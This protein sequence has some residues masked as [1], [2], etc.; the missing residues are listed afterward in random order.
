MFA[1][2]FAAYDALS[3]RMRRY[4]DG[5]TALHSF[6]HGFRHSLAEPGGW[7]RLGEA[8]RAN[9]P[10]RHPVVRTHPRSGRRALFVNR[11]FTTHIEGLREAESDAVLALPVR[12]P[13]DARA[14]LPLSLAARTRS[15]SGTTAPRCIGRSTTTSRRI[16]AWSASPSA[17]TDRDEPAPAGARRLRRRRARQALQGAGATLAGELYR[18]LLQQLEPDAHDRRRRARRARFR[19]ARASSTATTVSPGRART[20]PSIATPPA[21]RQQLDARARRVRRRRAELRELLGRAH[22]RHRRRRPLRRQPA[23]PRVRR[24]AQDRA[25]RAPARAHPMFDGK[26]LRLRRASPAT[27]TMSSRSAPRTT[28][29][30]GNE[31][32][33]VQAVQVEHDRGTFW[34]VQY[35]PEYELTRRRAARCAACAAAHR[36]RASSPTPPMRTDFIRQLEALHADRSRRDLIYR[37]AVGR[38]RARRAASAP[39]RRATGSSVWSN[40]RADDEEQSTRPDAG[41]AERVDGLR[42]RRR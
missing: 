7:D 19:P 21:V 11:L 10:V 29:L 26:P 28:V 39:A 17:A 5:L 25:H 41:R 31:F 9:P 3:D 33:P 35:H 27:K 32:S 20:S 13:R 24:R 22:R 23:R 4:L 16:A 12:A 36:A 40:R 6:A 37:L 34:A 8:V 2:L 42:R 30:A 18:R 38:R 15:R 14:Q 1:S